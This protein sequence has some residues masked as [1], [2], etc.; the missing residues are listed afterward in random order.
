[1]V[2]PTAKRP[3][4]VEGSLGAAEGDPDAPTAKANP[5]SDDCVFGVSTLSQA[6]VKRL[7]RKY[8]FPR[9]LTYCLPKDPRRV[10]ES[11]EGLFV[12]FEGAL[13]QGLRVP[14]PSFA[15][16]VL[17]SFSLHPSLLQP[18]SWG[19]MI[20]FLVKCIESE[21]EATVNLFKE[22]HVISAT[23][24]MIGYFFKS[25]SGVKKL[26]LNPTQ[27]IENWRRKYFLIKDFEGFIPSPWCNSLDVKSPNKK[28]RLTSAEKIGLSK[29]MALEPE[30]VNSTITEDHL[31]QEG[32]SVVLGQGSSSDGSEEGVSE[33]EGEQDSPLPPMSEQTCIKPLS[34]SVN[35]IFTN[36]CIFGSLILT[37]LSSF[38]YGSSTRSFCYHQGHRSE[39]GPCAYWTET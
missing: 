29:L 3:L 33:G 21:I 13:S 7:S 9:G 19:F 36:L 4:D 24:K 27:S 31:V 26:L 38:S 16:S 23:P 10:T 34:P 18:Q 30:D 15:I 11:R 2:V 35:D 37:L 17:V 5:Q 22:F 6:E 1:M 39:E 28:S 25:R 32:L 14:V 8:H 12:A 20:G